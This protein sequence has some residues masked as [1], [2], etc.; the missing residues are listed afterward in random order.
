MGNRVDESPGEEI[1]FYISCGDP[2]PSRALLQ[3]GFLSKISIP[4]K[5]GER[6]LLHAVLMRQR[7]RKVSPVMKLLA[8]SLFQTDDN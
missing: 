2:S 7:G 5:N 1:R 4:G 3:P 6:L 8:E